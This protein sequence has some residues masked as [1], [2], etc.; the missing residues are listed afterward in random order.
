M[1]LQICKLHIHSDLLCYVIEDP[2][3]KI[4]TLLTL[5]FYPF[6]IHGKKITWSFEGYLIP[7]GWC[8]LASFISLHMDEENYENPYDFNPWR[9][10]VS[11]VFIYFI[12]TFLFRASICP[13]LT[14]NLLFIMTDFSIN[15]HNSDFFVYVYRKQKLPRTAT[16]S[17]PLAVDRG[18]V[19]V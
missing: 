15:N 7:K 5:H 4:F 18:C 1:P 13:S 3:R 10:E 17:H 12:F 6:C 19:L 9:W 2:N 14:N 8:V 16:F 11:H